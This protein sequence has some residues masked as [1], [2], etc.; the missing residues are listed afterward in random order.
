ILD[1]PLDYTRPQQ[2]SF[3][4]ASVYNLAGKELASKIKAF[5]QQNQVTEYMIFLSAAMILL[6]KYSRHEDIVIGSPISARTHKDTENMLGMFVNTLAMRGKPKGQK[7]YKQFLEEIKQTCLQAYENQEYPFEELVE[8][9]TVHRDM[10]RNPLFDV[11]LVLQNNESVELDLNGSSTESIEAEF[12]VAKFDLTFGIYEVEDDYQMALEYCTDLYKKESAERLLVH[13]I[14]IINQIV[15]NPTI[16]LN[17]IETTT[18]EEKALII[19]EFNDT[20]HA[21]PRDKTVAEL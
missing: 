6:E 4:G 1:M 20:Y 16:K 18:E 13:L 11:M 3:A 21:Y 7:T 5:S 17:E 8:E 10:S 19:G 12:K 15:R 14:S 9:V 2:Q